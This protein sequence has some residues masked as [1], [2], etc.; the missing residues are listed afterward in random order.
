MIPISLRNVIL[1]AVA[2]ASIGLISGC[3]STGEKMDSN[4]IQQI[5]KGVTTRTQLETL[6]GPPRHVDILSDGRRRLFYM[7]YNNQA[8]AENFIPFIG[9]RLVGGSTGERQELQVILGKNNVVEDYEFSDSKTET[10]GGDLNSA[11][12]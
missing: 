8:K 2:A 5:Q 1:T 10:S 4:K 7:F 6:L 12:K 9:G 11:S 3:A